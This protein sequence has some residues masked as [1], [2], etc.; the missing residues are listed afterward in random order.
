MGKSDPFLVIS[1]LI[2]NNAVNNNDSQQEEQEQ[3]QKQEEFE[4]VYT[5]ETILRTLNPTW[6]PITLSLNA[7]CNSVD[8]ENTLLKF[9]CFDEISSTSSESIGSFTITIKELQV[10]ATAVSGNKTFPLT[11]PL[12]AK[13]KPNY[14]HSGLLTISKFEMKKQ[15]TFLEYVKS[16]FDLNLMVAFDFSSTK[17][18]NHSNCV[19]VVVC[20]FF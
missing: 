3:Q 10:K 12:L 15:H 4:T 20:F 6:K 5:T 1:K 7:L 17:R 16:G 14:Q 8:F 19:F 2:K 13:I 11:S 9:E 18:C